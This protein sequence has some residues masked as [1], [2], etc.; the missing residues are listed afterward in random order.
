MMWFGEQKFEVQIDFVHNNGG[1]LCVC[2]RMLIQ[3]IYI[4]E[5]DWIIYS[6]TIRFLVVVICRENA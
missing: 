2:P 6:T 3:K 1:G 5:Q 4:E